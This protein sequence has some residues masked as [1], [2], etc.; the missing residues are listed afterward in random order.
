MIPVEL[1]ERPQWVLWR[2][3]ERDGKATKA[4]HRASDP[5]SRASATDPATWAPFEVAAE[6]ASLADGLGYVFA[7]DDPYCGVD[8]DAC[9]DPETGSLSPEAGG[10]VAALDSYSEASPSGTGVHVLVEAQLPPEGANRN[11]RI[12]MYDRNRYFTVTGE[13]VRGTPETIE[14]RQAKL[15][16]VRALFLPPPKNGSAPLVRRPVDLDDRDLLDKAFAARNGAHFEALWNGDTTGYPSASE[17]DLALCGMLA[18]WTGGD[19]DRID[20]LFRSSGLMRP[21]WERE[22]YRTRTIE[23][24]IGG[25]TEFNINIVSGSPPGSPP[26]R[27]DSSSPLRPDPLG[28][29]EGELFAPGFAP[30]SHS[31]QP[32][33]LVASTANPPEPPDVIGLFYIGCNHLISGLSESLKTWLALTAAVGELARGRGVLWVDGD[34]VGRGAVLERLRLLDADD[35][36]IAQRFAYIAPD[37]PLDE[38][39][40]RDVLEVVGARAC[41]LA[42]FDGFNPCLS[43]TSSTPTQAPTW[44]GSTG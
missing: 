7:E 2:F 6:A 3:E 4:P 23:A 1:R 37:E 27:P 31:W 42:V 8:L 5:S 12:E 22:D 40:T 20:R 14:E 18:F 15:D 44:S 32:R 28:R 21:K 11:G 43:C 26:V 36:A 41:R 30:E 17:A 38:A 25:R 16:E 34:D 33:E 13:H 39:R 29:G 24:V 35:H 10:I 9:R 19:A